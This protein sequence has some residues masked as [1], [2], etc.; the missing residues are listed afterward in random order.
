MASN[1]TNL[2]IDSENQL[3]QKGQKFDKPSN[4]MI[5]VDPTMEGIYNKLQDWYTVEEA[6]ARLLTSKGQQRILNTGSNQ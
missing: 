3:K 5:W 6:T 2:V 1:L 4:S